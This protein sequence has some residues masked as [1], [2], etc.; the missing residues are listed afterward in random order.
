ME[1]ISTQVINHDIN[2]L[3]YH[4]RDSDKLLAEK[5]KGL[6]YENSAELDEMLTYTRGDLV[7]ETYNMLEETNYDFPTMDEI[8]K[9]M[10]YTPGSN[11]NLVRQANANYI[12]QVY[13]E[14]LQP[15]TTTDILTNVLNS[16][17]DTAG[18][19]GFKP[20]AT[21]K[22]SIDLTD[23]AL[24]GIKKTFGYDVVSPAS[25]ELGFSLV[26]ALSAGRSIYRSFR[27]SGGIQ[28]RES[29]AL[30]VFMEGLRQLAGSNE[31]NINLSTLA[32]YY[33]DVQ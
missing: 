11:M 32:Q 5:F 27:Q 3:L 31:F 14:Q 18:L 7:N 21:V 15:T 6:N 8:D 2:E 16:G 17:V 29:T 1:S 12:A 30:N 25:K 13:S 19:F 26:K 33:D 9:I 28:G 23:R 22:A 24:N 4:N 10:T 20:S